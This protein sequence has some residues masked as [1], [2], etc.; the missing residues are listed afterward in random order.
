MRPCNLQIKKRGK[1][2]IPIPIML[3]KSVGQDFIHLNKFSIVNAFFYK[4]RFFVISASVL[5]N[6][7]IN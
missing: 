3:P 5:L 2:G 1:N 6:F 4:Q 7:F